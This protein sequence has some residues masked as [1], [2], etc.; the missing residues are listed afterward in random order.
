MQLM[1]FQFIHFSVFQKH[2]VVKGNGA[3]AQHKASV[4]T[5]KH[6][7]VHDKHDTNMTFQNMVWRVWYSL[8]QDL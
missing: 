2:D 3:D 1:Q 7:L 8:L 5:T 6:T 4:Q